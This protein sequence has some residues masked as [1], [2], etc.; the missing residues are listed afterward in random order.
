MSTE[1]APDELRE[2]LLGKVDNEDVNDIHYTSPCYGMS[3]D[4]RRESWQ[5]RVDNKRVMEI[6]VDSVPPE[7]HIR[8]K[9]FIDH[10]LSI[11]RDG[12]PAGLSV[13]IE[14]LRCTR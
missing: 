8:S 6:G 2:F 13:H 10:I 12:G 3:W 4:K 7:F 5:I 11:L 9:E 1:L 14:E